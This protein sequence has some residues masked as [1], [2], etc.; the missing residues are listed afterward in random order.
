MTSDEA[1]KFGTWLVGGLATG[2]LGSIVIAFKIGAKVASYDMIASIK[3]SVDDLATAL[4]DVPRRLTTL[5]NSH[6]KLLSDHHQLKT[7]VAEVDA[8]RK[9][10][11]SKHDT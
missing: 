4:A 9:A 10:L 6:A 8:V 2:I 5:E 11:G 1:L 7:K 3:K